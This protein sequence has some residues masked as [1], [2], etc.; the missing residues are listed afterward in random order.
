MVLDDGSGRSGLNSRLARRTCHTST[1]NEWM[2]MIKEWELE[3]VSG[4]GEAT[5]GHQEP[6]KPSTSTNSSPKV[7]SKEI[8]IIIWFHD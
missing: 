6:K 8:K 1:S 2:Q 4:H 3:A 5:E 7:F